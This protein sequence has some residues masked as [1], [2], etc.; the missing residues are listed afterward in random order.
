MSGCYRCGISDGSATKL[1]ET[2]RSHRLP[3]LPN[4]DIVDSAAEATGIELS[5]RAQRWVLSGGALLYFGILGLGLLVQATKIDLR[6][7]PPGGDILRFGGNE[8]PVNHEN[9]FGFIAGPSGELNV[10]N[11]HLNS[12]L[13]SE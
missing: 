1:C 7:N 2:C 9:E 4:M 10:E 11:R 12:E 6:I 3:G 8:Y 13:N 5:P